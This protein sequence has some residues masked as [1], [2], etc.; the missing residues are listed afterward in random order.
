MNW[1][2]GLLIITTILRGVGAGI[3]TGVGIITLPVRESLG[4]V[5]FAVFMRAHYKEIGVKIYAAITILGLILTSIVLYFSYQRNEQ[6]IF[7]WLII[8]SLGATVLV[9]TGGAFPAMIKLWK[10]NNDD[11]YVLKNLLNR[12]AKWHLFSAIFH[13]IAFIALTFAIPYI[14]QQ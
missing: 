2:L 7:I 5:A 9:G 13:V 3:I 8:L 12:F 10:T 14:R 1:F 4:E 11:V 6:S